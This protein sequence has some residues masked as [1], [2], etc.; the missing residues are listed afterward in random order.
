MVNQVLLVHSIVAEDVALYSLHCIRVPRRDEGEEMVFLGSLCLAQIH[1]LRFQKR[2]FPLQLYYQWIRLQGRPLECFELAV[3]LLVFVHQFP[4]GE[5]LLVI[6][7]SFLSQTIFG[8]PQANRVHLLRGQRFPLLVLHF[9]TQILLF[10]S[11]LL[12]GDVFDDFVQTVPF[13]SELLNWSFLKHQLLVQGLRAVSGVHRVLLIQD[14]R[15]WGNLIHW[16]QHLVPLALQRPDD[17]L[18]RVQFFGDQNLIE[19]RTKIQFLLGISRRLHSLFEHPFVLNRRG[20]FVGLISVF[21]F[22]I[23]GLRKAKHVA[24]HYIGL[25]WVFI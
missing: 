2:V 12:L 19:R 1:Q 20:R 15:A 10:Q 6:K 13:L 5:V 21:V 4:D 3:Q 17:A 16:A 25:D 11:Q 18:V 24:L 22:E 8:I 9:Q 7:C 23:A 14:L